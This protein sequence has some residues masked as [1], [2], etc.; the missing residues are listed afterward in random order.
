[1]KMYDYLVSYDFTCTKYLTPCHGTIQIS[2]KKKVKT[3][4]D[5]NSMIEFIS[6]RL[7]EGSTNVAINNFIFLGRNNH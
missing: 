5:V 1:M 7:P 4:E 6:G 2:R 3:F